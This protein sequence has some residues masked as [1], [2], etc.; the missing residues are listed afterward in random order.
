MAQAGLMS[1]RKTWSLLAKGNTIVK[2]STIIPKNFGLIDTFG[3]R[4]KKLAIIINR[5]PVE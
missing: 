4:Y 3:N 2:I 5:N 1:C